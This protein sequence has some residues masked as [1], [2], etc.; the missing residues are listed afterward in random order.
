MIKA[1]GHRL[2]RLER[3]LADRGKCVAVCT[4][5]VTTSFHDPDCLDAILKAMPRCCPVHGFRELGFF[6]W[7][8]G[9]VLLENGDND[10][11]PCPPH[12][13]RTFLQHGFPPNQVWEER[14]KAEESWNHY[15]DPVRNIE[16]DNRRTDGIVDTYLAAR[17]EWLVSGRELPTAK[18]IKAMLWKRIEMMNGSRGYFRMCC[19]V[20]N[21]MREI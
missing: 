17:R 18:E 15:E 11:C 3:Q 13:W 21:E 7:R 12:P 1:L 16:E 8:P 2:S 10:F 14:R 6:F 5:R 19:G 4:C 20:H 9:W